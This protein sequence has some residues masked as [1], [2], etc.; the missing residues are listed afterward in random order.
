M[1]NRY[2]RNW[3]PT[4]RPVWYVAVPVAVLT[5]LLLGGAW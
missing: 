5:L 2:S 3:T 1:R 4:V